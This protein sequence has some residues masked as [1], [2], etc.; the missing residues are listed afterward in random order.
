M[1]V[2]RSESSV[3]NSKNFEKVS[4][5]L[6]FMGKNGKDNN[7]LSQ[8][9]DIFTSIFAAAAAVVAQSKRICYFRIICV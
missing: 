4:I 6:N 1:F 7:R 5:A 8:L 3:L 9:V 2:R